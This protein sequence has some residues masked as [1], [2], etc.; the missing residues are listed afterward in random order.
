M[1]AV[2]EDA[3]RRELAAARTGGA[4]PTVPVFDAGTGPRPGIDLTSNRVLSE[5]LDEGLELNSRK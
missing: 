2:I 1:G 3:L 5:V 4:R